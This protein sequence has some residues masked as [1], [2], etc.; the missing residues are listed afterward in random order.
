MVLEKD[1]NKTAQWGIDSWIIEDRVAY[2]WTDIKGCPIT[3]WFNT[4]DDAL[5]YLVSV[6]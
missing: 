4:F 1:Y 2:R 3:D 5:N 6:V